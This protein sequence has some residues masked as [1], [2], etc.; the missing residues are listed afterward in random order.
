MSKASRR[1]RREAAGANRSRVA[2]LSILALGASLLAPYAI[3][4]EQDAGAAKEQGEQSTAKSD[5]DLTEILV[6][7][8]RK[9]FATSQ[10]IKREADTV[11]DSITASDIGAFPD[12][13]VAEALQ[14]M[15][16]ITVTRFA[17]SGDT[18]H[19]SAEPSGVVNF[20]MTQHGR[21]AVWAR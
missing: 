6:T 16:G 8:I 2:E 14:R 1:L 13:S 19:F 18:T 15:S 12:K 21:R 4:Q 5:D 11:V 7:G 10:E 20:D 17:A 9:A 3:A